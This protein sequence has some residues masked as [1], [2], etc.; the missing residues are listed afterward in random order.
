MA[1]ELVDPVQALVTDAILLAHSHSDTPA[2]HSS[3]APFPLSSRILSSAVPPP[4]QVQE[5]QSGMD[6]SSRHTLLSFSPQSKLL[7]MYSYQFSSSTCNPSVVRLTC[8]TYPIVPFAMLLLLGY[9]QTPG[10]HSVSL[11]GC[12]AADESPTWTISIDCRTRHK[13]A[14]VG[15]FTPLVPRLSQLRFPRRVHFPGR[16]LLPW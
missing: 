11:Q 5:R 9:V 8:D 16:L 6:A 13:A 14:S 1:R 15:E 4:P 2:M 3:Y 12:G 10:T 7:R